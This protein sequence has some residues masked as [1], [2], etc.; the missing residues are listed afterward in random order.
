MASSTLHPQEVPL[1]TLT[2]AMSDEAGM[3]EGCPQSLRC[4]CLQAP[5]RVW[6]GV[7]PRGGRSCESERSVPDPQTG[8]CF[9]IHK[10]DLVPLETQACQGFWVGPAHSRSAGNRPEGCTLVQMGSGAS[11]TMALGGRGATR[12]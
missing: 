7:D 1:H 4:E 2:S 5:G 10:R 12:P 11:N 8:T 3:G 9:L 6:E